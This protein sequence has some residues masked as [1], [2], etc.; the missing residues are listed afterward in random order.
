MTFWGHCSTESEAAPRLA[1]FEG[2]SVMAQ[3]FVNVALMIAAAGAVIASLA[4]TIGLLTPFAC[5]ILCLE[6]VV[7]MFLHHESGLFMLFDSRAVSLQFVVMSAALIALG[8]GAAS[9]DARTFGRREVEIRGTQ[10]SD[11]P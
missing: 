7:A 8:P 3:P 2:L 10:R 9:M 11:D 4:V 6:G 5:A 1:G